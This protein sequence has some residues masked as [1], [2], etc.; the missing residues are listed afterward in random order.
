LFYLFSLGIAAIGSVQSLHVARETYLYRYPQIETSWL[1]LG[2]SMTLSSCLAASLLLAT[3]IL[4]LAVFHIRRHKIDDYKGRYR[5]WYVVI[6]VLGLASVDVITHAHRGL[7][8]VM[9]MLIEQP[10]WQNQATWWVLAWSFVGGVVA[11]R[12]LIEVRR[13]RLAV[14]TWMLAATC[15]AGSALLYLDRFEIAPAQTHLMARSALFLAGLHL[16]MFGAALYARF[17]YLE[18]QGAAKAAAKTRQKSTDRREKRSMLFKLPTF[19][20]DHGPRPS[21]QEQF[22]DDDDHEYD[23]EY[24]PDDLSD[25]PSEAELELLTNPDL[26]RSER[27]KL[28]KQMKRRRR[29]VAA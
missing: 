16:L 9:G 29:Q 20:R 12:A 4:A 14:L 15:L 8:D 23:E 21:R 18:A 25:E 7:R 1:A 2:G 3:A 11:L 5:M 27:R 10:P 13:C 17:V 22:D 19:G 28:K 6:V 26:T 24:E